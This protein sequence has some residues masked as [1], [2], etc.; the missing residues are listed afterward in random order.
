VGDSPLSECE[1]GGYIGAVRHVLALVSFTLLASLALVLHAT[2]QA[3]QST[4]T[5]DRTMVCAAAFSGGIYELEAE[6]RAGAV[7]RGSSWEKPATT[8][9]T[10][11]GTGSSFEL[12]DNALVW[13]IAGTPTRDATVIP[14]ERAFG[15]HTYPIR[16]WGTLAMAN[17]CRVSRTPPL[18]SPR[19]LRGGAVDWLGQNFDCPSSRHIL[20]RVRATLTASGTL[21]RG[22]D[23]LRTTTPLREARVVVATSSGRRLAYAEVLNSGRARLFTAPSCVAD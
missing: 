16:A 14:D 1:R 22:R 12:L 6:A 18:L 11:G 8:I 9:V 23:N 20:V 21:S 13:A 17:R 3:A 2:A 10:T 5:V 15:N 7:R 4:R 19:G